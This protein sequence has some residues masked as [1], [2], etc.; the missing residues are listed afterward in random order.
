MKKI[1]ILFVFL[2]GMH[3]QETWPHKPHCGLKCKLKKEEKKAKKS[4]TKAAQKDVTKTTTEVKTAAKA[5][6]TDTG[7]AAKTVGTD[8]GKAAK[9]AGKDV[10]K[11]SEDIYAGFRVVYKDISPFSKADACIASTA[12]L[13]SA[14]S[15]ANLPP[16][17]LINKKFN[18]VL[19]VMTHNSTSMKNIDEKEK[20]AVAASLFGVIY[21]KSLRDKVENDLMEATLNHMNLVADQD[22]TLVQQLK[23][24]V[25]SFKLPL[26]FTRPY[27]RI[28][29]TRP[30]E[31]YQDMYKS[32][33]DKLK[34]KKIPGFIRKELLKP[35]EG[36][37]KGLV[38]DPCK[39]DTSHCNLSSALNLMNKWLDLHPSEV[40]SF[41]FDF[42]QLTAAEKKDPNT[43]AA[44][45]EVLQSSGLWDK[46]YIKGAQNLTTST[47]EAIENLITTSLADP[48]PTI[49]E[50][51]STNKRV[52]IVANTDAFQS[53]GVFHKANIG[54]GSNYNYSS[55]KKL[56][57][58]S[59][60]PKIDW[61]C[62]TRKNA[63][64]IIDNYV[65]GPLGSGQVSAALVANEKSKL[66]NRL[67]R[68]IDLAGQ[69]V[70]LLMVDFYNLPS[71]SDLFNMVDF[72]NQQSRESLLEYV[73]GIYG[74]SKTVEAT[75]VT[76]ETQRAK[77]CEPP[78]KIDDRQK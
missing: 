22:K 4:A 34:K 16:A 52:V 30:R 66:K 25:R 68:Y 2:F 40:V 45:K 9:T 36:L 59:N 8:T 29:H 26:N 5:A 65:T 28:C 37:V 67:N 55:L 41:F 21:P 44:F 49:G 78:T 17:Y 24:G 20:K 56:D 27:F 47:A 32:A 71:T 61:G 75:G 74:D 38:K 46:M 48:W 13:K 3:I 58:D 69:P 11:V 64:F 15:T 73:D 42:S 60:N 31:A 63:L 35:L 43:V 51:V 23:D 39:I 72:Y 19:F 33:N 6:G 14:G 54:F 70:C 18:E 1:L 57:A 50:M 76:I 7:K 62:A 53:L 12:E 10:E 77:F